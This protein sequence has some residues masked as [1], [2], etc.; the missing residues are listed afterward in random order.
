L[1]CAPW[2]R[3]ARSWWARA[4]P[5][6][7]TP[8]TGKG[9]RAGFGMGVSGIGDVNGDSIPDLMLGSGLYTASEDRRQLGIVGVY[10]SPRDAHAPHP[11]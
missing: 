6:R 1:G 7:I 8:G 9:A 4:P 5:A 3:E 11:V 10:L 2:L